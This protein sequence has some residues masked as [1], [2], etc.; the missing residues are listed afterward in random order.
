MAATNADGDGVWTAMPRSNSARLGRAL[1][2]ALFLGGSTSSPLSAVRSGVISTASDGTQAYD[3]RVTVSSG[4]TLSVNPV[5]AIIGRSGQGPYM[6]WTLPPA[7]TV[8]CDTAPATNPRNDIVIAR[9]YDTTLSDVIQG[10]GVI[11]MRIEIVTGTPGPTPADPVTWD[12]LGLITT[13]PGAGG[14][15]AI[16]LARAQVST[17]GVVTLTDLRRGTGLVGGVRVL[18]P[19]DSLSD[20]SFMPSDMRWFN[21][22]DIWDGTKWNPMW[23]PTTPLGRM[24]SVA[25]LS[26]GTI[27][28]TEAVQTEAVTFT[29][30]SGRRYE[31]SHTRSEANATGSPILTNRFRVA[32]GASISTGSTLIRTFV[33]GLTGVY[34]TTTRVCEWTATFSGQCT[35]GLTSLTNGAGTAQVDAARERDLTVKD[36]GV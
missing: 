26:A 1:L 10:G 33:G 16:P 20:P 3:G 8:T 6:G 31:I 23:R 2:Q 12:S 34:V 28:T 17:G 25:P 30:V 22:L 35:I 36:I 32:S 4:R 24:G 29:A 9:A 7:R 11:P 18:L 13:I 27:N 14:G 15:V 5:I 19:G 21:G